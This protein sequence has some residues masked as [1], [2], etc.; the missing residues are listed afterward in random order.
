M[1][2]MERRAGILDALR[3]LLIQESRERLLVIVIEDLHWVDEKSEEALGAMV[4][5]IQSLPMLMFLTYRPGYAH[6]LGDRTYY[7]RVSLSHLQV[8]ES[9]A[10]AEKVLQV[11]ALPEQ[12]RSLITSKGEGNPFYVEEV[13]KSLLESGVLITSDGVC[14]LERPVDQVRVPDTIQEVI[15]SRI[16]RLEQEAREAIQLASV[17]G[18]EFTVRLL[19]RISDVEAKVDE[20]LSELKQLELIYEKAYFPELAYMFKH[21]LTHDVAYSTLLLERR[22]NLHRMVGAAIE[23][24]YADRL[25][26]QYEALAYHYNQG[27]EWE[28]ALEYLEKAGDKAAAAYANQ[29]ALDYYARALAV[30]D[31]LGEPALERT[32]SICQR[33]AFVRMGLGD[34]IGSAGDFGA[35][36][37][38][39]AK[40]ADRQTEAMALTLQGTQILYAHDFEAAEK[41]LQEAIDLAGGDMPEA[42]FLASGTLLFLNAVLNRREEMARYAA[43]AS[44][45][46]SEVQDPFS[47]WQFEFLKGMAAHWMGDDDAALQTNV[48]SRHLAEESHAAVALV[49]HVWT[50]SLMRGA[51]GEYSRALRLLNSLLVFSDRVGDTAGKARILNTIGWMYGELQ[52]HEEA[53][54][55]NEKSIEAAQ[56]IKAYSKIEIEANARLNLADSLMALGREDEAEEHFR[57]VEQVVRNPQPPE[58]WMLWRY[59]QHMFHSYGEL[60]LARGDPAKAISYADDCL[61]L[62]EKSES[63]KIIVKAR[64]LRGQALVAL[65]RPAEAEKEIDVAL[66]T[67]REVGNPPQLW[68][69]LVALGDL[70]KAQAGVDEARQA[71]GE[72]VT[73]IDGIATALEDESL[74]ETFLSSPHVRGIR[75]A[76][77]A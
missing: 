74:R 68:K 56:D 26:E 19:D 18:R 22:K 42:R 34:F 45:L 72:A 11:T 75:E 1:D 49:W 67:A 8:E 6:S 2:P 60:W 28:K 47:R 76:A 32:P 13:T 40:L 12:V 3:A 62:A 77:T 21:A 37:E 48:G 43:R 51:R 20:V 39:A 17:I 38:R 54:V 64:R 58:R 24:L 30:A 70:R 23:D 57:W 33:V 36:R 9:G 41:V 7:S 14:T 4:D 16:D 63:R 59:A 53:L 10:I 50:E 71:Y 52:D 69:T 25:A 35:M 31:R 65:G 61:A 55:W 46:V 73:V 29:D 15:L 66:E 44:E 27:Q 5:A